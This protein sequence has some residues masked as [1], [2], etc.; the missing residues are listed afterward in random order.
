MLQIR[1]GTRTYPPMWSTRALRRCVAGLSAIVAA[2][3]YLLAVANGL[4]L[5]LGFSCEVNVTILS[6]LPFLA[7]AAAAALSASGLVGPDAPLGRVGLILLVPG[8]VATA[9]LVVLTLAYPLD[10]NIASA[11]IVT[12]AV[13]A[14]GTPI[15]RRIPIML[16]MLVACWA[17][18]LFVSLYS[19]ATW[20]LGSSLTCGHNLL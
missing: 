6:A 14:V 1:G 7:A 2:W 5:H 16:L 9:V 15:R 18:G 11:V 17:F 4:R 19:L 3:A 20:L 8:T 12:A 10:I 13:L